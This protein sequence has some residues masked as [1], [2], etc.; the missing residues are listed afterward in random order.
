ME[1]KKKQ[2]KDTISKLSTEMIKEVV[3]GIKD[4]YTDES[5]IVISVC[6]DELEKR[7][8]EKEFILFC[9]SIE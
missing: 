4:T 8:E 6:L 3:N 1:N 9:K 5:D 7:M 2:L